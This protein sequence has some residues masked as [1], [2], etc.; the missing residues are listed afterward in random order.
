MEAGITLN[1]NN[2]RRKTYAVRMGELHMGSEYPVRIQ[3]MTNTPTADVQATVQQCIS[4][5]NAGGELV[6]IT[7]PSLSDADAAE[8][9][10]ADFRAQH[11]HEPLAADVHF[12]ARVALKV[13]PFMDKVRINPGNFA[14]KRNNVLNLS[15]HE[16]QLA[17]IEVKKEFLSL[18]HVCKSNNT[19]LRIGVNH[20]SLSSRIM[21][22][23]GDTPEGMA[24]SA[25][26]FL[27]FCKEENF[28]DVVV[29]MKSSNT[30]VMADS[31]ML[32]V[33]KMQQEQMAFPVHL[34]VTEAGE[35]EDG[36]IKSAIGI[37]AMLARGIGD[38]IRVSLTEDPEKEIPVAKEI[39]GFFNSTIPQEY[40]SNPNDIFPTSYEGKKTSLAGSNN[41]PVVIG[42]VYSHTK[43][44]PETP[45][46]FYFC[47][48]LSE[49]NS[50]S[51]GTNIIA[52]YP[53]WTHT[54]SE[55]IF[56]FFKDVQEFLDAGKTSPA[57]NYVG[58][59]V[60]AYAGLSTEISMQPVVLV[61]HV[62]A[63]RQGQHQLAM[64]H[65][66]ILHQ[67]IN[68][69]L[70]Y[71]LQFSGVEKDM[72]N[73]HAACTLAPFLL[74]D[75]PNGIWV[76]G[77]GDLSD[78]VRLAYGLLQASRM[79]ITQTEFISCPSCG[80]TNFDLQKT[81]A[82]IKAETRH[83]KNLKIGIMGCIV[84]G[85]GEMA[86]ADFGYVGSGKGKITLYKGKTVVKKNIP[87]DNAV[88]E[89]ILLIKNSGM[90]QEQ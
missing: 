70:I 15:D 71:K 90:W 59:N 65:K 31:T 74:A 62:P 9:I 47:S 78:D 75:A 55:A 89:L 1:M 22:R 84:N 72:I 30:R 33:Q 12:N 58:I 51:E 85:P 50:I 28:S 69:P 83:L 35:G 67:G 86:D 20:G 3:S 16:Y 23:Y 46:D 34:G 52:P 25:M 39:I 21:N 53:L 40:T 32:V 18:L 79:R 82:R 57:L 43:N 4:I 6:R 11:Y 76:D 42:E 73:I 29:S 49:I 37:G 2:Y 56:P 13:A 44:M 88:N 17:L 80:R 7:V 8:K 45:A 14:D 41:I 48:S 87:E 68:L 61:V 64:F 81:T 24:E 19:A 60:D 66:Y 36:R 26:E 27:R 38:T 77:T 63:T 10:V 54:N 5:V